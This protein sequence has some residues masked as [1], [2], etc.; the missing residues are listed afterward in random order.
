HLARINLGVLLRQRGEI[1]EARANFRRVLEDWPDWPWTRA[2]ALTNLASLDQQA[3]RIDDAVRQLREAAQLTPAAQ[4]P[5]Y[6]LANALVLQGHPD[7]AIPIY[8]KLLE[9]TPEHIKARYNL[10]CALEQQG[11]IDEAEPEF[12]RV[13]EQDARF[14]LGWTGV[15]RVAM[16]KSKFA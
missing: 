6:N 12:R 7:E 10:G 11:K 8:R 13:V 5:R 9:E 16:A 2:R 1:D 14:A 3:G 15:G 4:E